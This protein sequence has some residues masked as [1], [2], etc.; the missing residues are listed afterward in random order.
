M[1]VNSD[2]NMEGALCM[3]EWTD[4]GNVYYFIMNGLDGARPKCGF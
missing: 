3:R 4:A 1:L 2:Y